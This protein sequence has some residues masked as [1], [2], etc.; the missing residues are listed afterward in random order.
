M[1]AIKAA[2]DIDRNRGQFR[3]A[4]STR[5]LSEPSLAGSAE[6]GGGCREFV[7]RL[8]ITLVSDYICELDQQEESAMAPA[9][10]TR[11]QF[12]RTSV[13]TA[14]LATPFGLAAC[15][16]VTPTPAPS[17]FRELSSRVSG[18]LL[19]P[20]D[21]A[22]EAASAPYN[23]A[24]NHGPPT[25]IL[26]AAGAADVAA[27]IDFVRN[28]DMPFTVRGGGHSYASYSSTRGLLIN[29]SA[30]NRVDINKSAETV[31]IGPG[32]NLGG[33]YTQLAAVGVTIPGGS[34]PGV[35]ISGLTLGGGYGLLGRKYGVLSDNLLSTTN[36]RADG[37][38]AAAD[39][40]ENGDL[41]WA[42]RGGGG[43]N[44][45]T[46]T[47]FTFRTYPIGQVFRLHVKWSWD[48]ARELF[49]SWQHWSRTNP[50]DLT[51]ICALWNGGSELSDPTKLGASIIGQYVGTSEA[52]LRELLAPFIEGV[53]SRPIEYTIT[54]QNFI[55][56]V[57][58]FAGCTPLSS[59]PTSADF[60]IK[61]AY[62][63][64]PY[65]QQAIDTMV[66][67]IGKFPGTSGQFVVD[68]DSYGGAATR[69]AS[70]ATAFVHR[71]ALS[72]GQWQL[73]WA[74]SDDTQTVDRATAWF[75]DLFASMSRAN[76]SSAYVNYIDPKLTDWQAAYYGT[77]YPRLQQV[78]RKYDPG[79]LFKFDQSIRA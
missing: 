55:D 63:K 45:A 2:V 22:F 20:G 31:T 79:N 33:I 34:C 37:Q 44:F 25:A 46:T 41:F 23:Q 65:S 66:D 51:T 73:F 68:F 77:N 7:G 56:A 6:T 57:A 69:P 47:G 26:L 17:A 70:N 76:S 8:A 59:C 5:F 60:Y 1:L 30:M 78:K 39:A 64:A 54:Q 62:V 48:H 13:A 61:S 27:G 43:G 12:L 10:M 52:E 67:G 72:C 58:L 29:T 15:S 18:R 53:G 32:A 14:A 50:D 40:R 3:L 24:I 4:G 19:V 49:D 38:L 28:H 16:T 74:S 36:V 35:G 11:R 42:L 75:S 9:P 21:S 71:D